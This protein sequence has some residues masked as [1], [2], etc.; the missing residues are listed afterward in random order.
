MRLLRRW[1]ARGA[2]RQ[3]VYVVVPHPDDEFEAWS[4]LA[5]AADSYPVFVL[6]THGEQTSLSDGRGHQPELGEWTPPPQPWGEPGSATVRAQRLASFHAFL[7]AMADVDQHLDRDLV[8][9][10]MLT[11]G[12][13]AFR[14]HVG[15][16]SARVVFDGGDGSLTP[17]FVTAA[18]QR[19]RALRTTHLPVQREYAVI[20]AAY[21]NASAAGFRYTH[22]DHRAVH[23]ALWSTDQGVPGPQWCRTATADPD[24]VRTGG[25]TELVTAQT[26]DA[27]MAIAPDGRRTGLFQVLYGWLGP[28]GGWPAGETDAATMWSRQQSFWRRY[29]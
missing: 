15:P 28:S 6:C 3:I 22:P 11:D 21:V 18:V 4:L 14:L 19:T 8:D 29:S 17:E 25:R 10:G 23:E 7:D 5:D 20:G 12:P 16:R 26:Y 24:V 9:H 2:K 1:S 27:V 13:S